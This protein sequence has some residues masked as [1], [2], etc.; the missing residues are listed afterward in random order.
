MKR[1]SLLLLAT[2]LLGNEPEPDTVLRF[3]AAGSIQTGQYPCMAAMRVEDLGSNGHPQHDP[4]YR[5]RWH[6][7]IYGCQLPLVKD[8]WTNVTSS[9]RVGEM[10]LVIAGYG[11][12]RYVPLDLALRPT[13]IV[14]ETNWQ[15]VTV[16]ELDFQTY[17]LL[18]EEPVRN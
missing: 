14:S 15:R 9:F 8:L 16:M 18:I 2:V 3:H 12:L 11:M 7:L 5:N 10:A 4:A 1:F 13:F 6:Y 17:D